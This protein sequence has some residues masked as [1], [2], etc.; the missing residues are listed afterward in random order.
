MH[1]T[2]KPVE[3]MR[4]PMV[5]NSEPGQAI[6]EPF[7]GSGSTIIAAETA[8]R[9]CLAMEISPDY[10]DVAVLRWQAFTGEPAILDGE[11]PTFD[12]VAAARGTPAVPGEAPANKP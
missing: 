11:D 5:N 7:C 2:Q 9:A 6:Y 12:D 4:R 8:G 3:V 10:C 1:G